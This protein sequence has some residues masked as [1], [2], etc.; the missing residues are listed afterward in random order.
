[1]KGNVLLVDDE[2]AILTALSYLVSSAGYDTRTAT[3]GA[4]A[5]AAV[6]DFTPRVAVLDVMMPGMDGFEL[7]EQLRAKE[8]LSDV[9]IIFLTARGSQEDR[10]NGYRSGGEVYL[11]KPFDNDELLEVLADVL[12]FG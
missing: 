11:T 8:G 1:M 9:R 7:A 3:D 10:Y 4:T 5:L 2:P 12:S 6:D